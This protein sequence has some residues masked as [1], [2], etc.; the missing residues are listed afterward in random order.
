VQ[1]GSGA[2]QRPINAWFRRI[3]AKFRPKVC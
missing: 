2:G 3:L 1:H